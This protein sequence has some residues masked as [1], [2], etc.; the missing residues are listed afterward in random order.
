M[1]Q[2]STVL[3]EDARI[4]WFMLTT[5]AVV[6]LAAVLIFL[7]LAEKAAPHGVHIVPITATPSPIPTPWPTPFCVDC[8]FPQIVEFDD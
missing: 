8:T 4:S 6:V 1:G 7:S 2:A 3:S 5:G